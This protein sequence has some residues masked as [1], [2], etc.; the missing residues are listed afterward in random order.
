LTRTLKIKPATAYFEL[1]V[2][3]LKEDENNRLMGLLVPVTF[4]KQPSQRIN[5]INL[6][7]WKK[8]IPERGIL[9]DSLWI[10]PCR[11][12]AGAHTNHYWGNFIP[13]IPYQALIRFTREEDWV[14]D[15]FAGSGTT[16]ITCKQLNRN[17]I[18]IE[19]VPRVVALSNW[20]VR[21]QTNKRVFA[22]TITGDSTSVEARR[23][24]KAILA[25]HNVGQV[26]LIILH[27]PYFNIIHFSNYPR[28]L[29]NTSS[30]E[31][32]LKMFRQVVE[33]FAGLLEEKR[34]LML[35]M[36]DCYA[37]GEC[38][39]LAFKTLEEVIATG[40]FKLKGIIIKNIE[41]NRGK[42]GHEHLWQYRALKGGFYLFKH[43]YVF[44]FQKV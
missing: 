34:Y 21:T 15:A 33:N 38:V 16:L 24:V 14:L 28:D 26:Q 31:A 17:G 22:K 8:E 12:R 27:P 13:Q 5:D 35:V 9:L 41:G 30:L 1:G 3:S 36:G 10:I 4:R 2:K 19:L 23:R 44:V 6:K 25:A 40:L 7:Q 11:E 18:G 37:N 39:P 43:E 29:S 42:I 32:F 20:L